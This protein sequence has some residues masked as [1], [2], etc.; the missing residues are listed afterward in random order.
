MVAIT[1]PQKVSEKFAGFYQ[2]P[3]GGGRNREVGERGFVG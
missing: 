1:F 2:S 3:G